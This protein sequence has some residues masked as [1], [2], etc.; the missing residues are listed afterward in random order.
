MLQV[1]I[2]TR[3]YSGGGVGLEYP[4]TS[5]HIAFDTINSEDQLQD[6]RLPIGHWT[7]GS[8]ALS[9]LTNRKTLGQWLY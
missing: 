2:I 5:V 9:N 4:E 7:I 8:V 6:T 3:L 1:V